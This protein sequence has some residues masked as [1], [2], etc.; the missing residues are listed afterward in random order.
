MRHILSLGLAGVASLLFFWI[1]ASRKA[2][3][4][5]G[6]RHDDQ[7]FAMLAYQLAQGHWLGPYNELTLVKGP[8][9]PFFLAVNHLLGLPF[10]LGQGLLMMAAVGYFAFVIW[11]VTRSVPWSCATYVLVLLTPALFEPLR[12]IREFFFS[13]VLIALFASALHLYFGRPQRLIGVAA[14]LGLLI[15]TAWLTREE[16]VTLLPALALLLGAAALQGRNGSWAAGIR[17]VALPTGIAFGTAVA[18]LLMVAS[19]NALKYRVFTLNEIKHRDFQ[20][21]LTAMQRAAYP[22]WRPYIPVPRE[23]R[24]ALYEVSPTF[25]LLRNG[26][27]HPVGNWG[28]KQTCER[29]PKVCGDIAAGWFMWVLRGAAAE[30]GAHASGRTAVAF[31]RR[32]ADEVEAACASG[33]LTCAPFMLPLV[34][35]M[36]RAQLPDILDSVVR[37]IRLI[38]GE[39]GVRTRPAV[40]ELLPGPGDLMMHLL[41]RPPVEAFGVKEIGGWFWKAGSTDWIEASARAPNRILALERHDSRDIVAKT[42]QADAVRQRFTLRV[43]CRSRPCD[44]TLSSNASP[45]ARLILDPDRLT[46]GPQKTSDRSRLFLE[47]SNVGGFETIRDRVG[48]GYLALVPRIQIVH[49]AV[50][51]AGFVAFLVLL[52]VALVERRVP[53]HLLA[54][55]VLFAAVAARVVLV[56]LVDATSFRAVT[57]HYLLPASVLTVAFSTV[58]LAG[59]QEPLLKMVRRCKARSLAI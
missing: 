20:A 5:S 59:L 4:L 51:L 36:T 1:S 14:L 44:V 31:Y 40:S 57:S 53:F 47:A 41:N 56:A 26:L 43:E 15:A 2:T 13:A 39:R 16:G 32:I 34:P 38:S 29:L 12:V 50:N 30:T 58:A 48:L 42:G 22:H 18:V 24:L 10:T 8:A 9:Y 19:L 25:N 49:L 23:A 21:A 45:F 11:R 17:A 28:Y 54:A 3:I 33:R 6:A 35:P 37:S 27:E 55:G 52:I 46:L 7:L